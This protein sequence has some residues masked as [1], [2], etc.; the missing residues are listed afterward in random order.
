[1]MPN[2]TCFLIKK[3]TISCTFDFNTMNLTEELAWIEIS[4]SRLTHNISKIASLLNGVEHV[5]AVVK[6]NA[7]GHGIKTMVPLMMKNGIQ[8]FAVY[9]PEE[10]FE[11]RKAGGADC[12][13]ILLGY[14]PKALIPLL[15]QHHIDCMLLNPSRI[16][17]IQECVPED[18]ILHMHLKIDTGM[19][20][21]GI[22][23]NELP[24][25]LSELKS[26]TKIRLTGAATH[27]ANAWNMADGTYA[28]QQ[29]EKFIK[30]VDVIESEYGALTHIHIDNTAGVFNFPEYKC[31]FAR[32][33]IGL[34][35]YY[36]TLELK[37]H[38]ERAVQLKPIL[39]Y[40]TR[41]VSLKWLKA[42]EYAGY[43]IT[44][45]AERPTRI[46]LAPIGYSD[47]FPFAHSDKGTFVIINGHRTSLIGR[48]N[49]NA[50]FLDVTDVDD[51][52]LG[53]V[54]TL[55]G[56]DVDQKI[57]AWDWLEWGTP[58]LY[59]ALTSLRASLPKIVTA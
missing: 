25:F 19:A 7:Y 16:Q 33:G 55:L 46:A 8:K 6:G 21:F 53:S 28:R 47:G 37:S 56:Q 45:K 59:E 41:V 2:P 29:H 40:R 36:P 4:E 35:G 57:S 38:F 26:V 52:V 51:V 5:C 32:V 24:N 11:V 20:R 9:H 42:G 27:F 48:V 23:P 18:S 1:M 3:L 14:A 39:A 54:I 58:H 12:L 13:I 31:S 15:S 22:T 50:I 10:A 49:M 44:F 30:A 43:D 34:Y 17:E